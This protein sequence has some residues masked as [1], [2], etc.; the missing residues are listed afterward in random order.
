[1]KLIIPNVTRYN[2]CGTYH[3]GLKILISSFQ[4]IPLV[5]VYK[6]TWTTSLREFTNIEILLLG[7]RKL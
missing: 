5:S 3:T 4:S 7:R 6:T 1:M 2:N